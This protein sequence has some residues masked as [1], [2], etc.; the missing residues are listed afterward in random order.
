MQRTLKSVPDKDKQHKRLLLTFT[1]ITLREMLR[2][3]KIVHPQG[4]G[5]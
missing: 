5:S 1:G 2:R 3:E 4:E